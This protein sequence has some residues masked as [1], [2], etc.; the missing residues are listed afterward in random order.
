MAF[1]DVIPQN[2]QEILQNNLLD[3]VFEEALVPETLYAPLC[4]VREWGGGV[5]DTGIFTKRGILPVSVTP[6]T[7]A[8]APV[9]EY[10]FEQYKLR[11]DQW[12]LSMDTNMAVSAMALAS[13]WIEDNIAIGENAALTLNILARNALYGVYGEGAAYA[14]VQANSGATAIVLN[15]A[16]GFTQAITTF[17]A[18][19]GTPPEGL[20]ATTTPVLAPVSSSNPLTVTLDPAGANVTNT[21]TGV[22]LATNTIT[23]GS[24][25]SGN[26]VIGKDV[27]SSIAPVS[28]RV[29]GGASANDLTS[30]NIATLATFRTAQVRLKNMNVPRI[31]GAYTAHITPQTISELYADPEFQS[32]ARGAVES[33]VYRELAL[34]RFEGID[35]V[36]NNLTPGSGGTLAPVLTNVANVPYYRDIV[37][38]AGAVVKGPFQDMANLVA[39]LN[40]GNTV[41][42]TYHN[43]VARILRGP[44][45]RFGQV[46]TT[47]W[48]WIGGFTSPTDM[49]TGD[50]APYKRAVVIEHA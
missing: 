20:D 31:G 49:L 26:F 37:V 36:E 32:A 5:G 43:G 27:V 42:I 35:W 30:S 41:E 6:V 1:R 29:G 8:D 19:G 28:Y 47:T 44:L 48:S 9:S 21:V 39:R 13:K 7:G 15:D 22:N 14:T 25:L 10:G 16:S 24:A 34:G 50:S 4:D 33:P 23:L 3:R 46:L 11:M 2:L 45:D 12:G 38:G 17:A 18:T 40:A